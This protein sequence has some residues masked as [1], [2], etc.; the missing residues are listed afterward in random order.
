M[1]GT[2]VWV[3]CILALGLTCPAWGQDQNINEI[4][5]NSVL[6]EDLSYI[7]VAPKIVRPGHVYKAIVTLLDLDYSAIVIRG[8]VSRDGVQIASDSEK[9]TRQR[10]SI[11]LMMKVPSN[12]PA[13]DYKF[14]IDVELTD[15][16]T[17]L[18]TKETQLQFSSRS[19]TVVIQTNKAIYNFKDNVRARIV[20]LTTEQKPF[21]DP[22]D[23][24]VLEPLGY[25][26]RRWM[27]H[28]SS[29]GVMSISFKTSVDFGGGW[30]TIKVVAQ[31]QVIEQK[32]WIAAYFK[33]NIFVHV[34]APAFVLDSDEYIS[35]TVEVNKTKTLAPIYGSL[36]LHAQVKVPNRGSQSKIIRE[37]QKRIITQFYGVHNFRFPISELRS[38]IYPLPGA[39][40]EIRAKA[41][42]YFTNI[43]NT[44]YVRIRMINDT[45]SLRFL[46]T[47]PQ[48]F[49]PGMQF[50]TYIAVSYFD[51]VA[52]DPERLARSELTIVPDITGGSGSS[53]IGVIRT[54]FP[55]SGVYK[56][57]IRAPKKATKIEFRA[58]YRDDR[59]TESASLL[60]VA[61]YAPEEKY[62][63]VTTSTTNAMVGQFIVFH[64]RTN[65]HIHEFH[66]IVMSKGIIQM[67]ATDAV[68]GINSVSQSFAVPVSPAMS[69]STTLVVYAIT[70]DKKIIA[71]SVTV[72]V[73][74][75][76]RNQLYFGLLPKKDKTGKTIEM[77]ILNYPGAMTFIS[78]MDSASFD[79]QTKNEINQYN[80][81]NEMYKFEEQRNKL[82]RIVW[83]SRESM[84]STRHYYMTSNYGY[85]TLDVFKTV[86]LVIHSDMDVSNRTDPCAS[87]RNRGDR[88]GTST[89]TTLPPWMTGYEEDRQT[90]Y[91]SCATDYKC[92]SVLYRCDGRSHCFDK[93]DEANC[94]SDDDGMDLESA[95]FY[96]TR[97]NVQPLKYD[98]T[99]KD[100]AWQD[101]S[102]GPNE[103]TQVAINIPR[104]PTNWIFNAFSM[105]SE[106]GFGFIDQPVIHDGRIP[107]HMA[108]EAPPSAVVYEQIGVR[109]IA[110][111][112]L[113][114]E[115]EV[116]LNVKKSDK[117]QFVLVDGL[118][119]VSHYNPR[120][121]QNN[122]QH[123]IFIKPNSYK[124]VHFPVV[125][126]DEGKIVV[127]INGRA[128]VGV[129]QV[130]ATIKIVN[131]GAM[132]HHHTALLLNLRNI[133]S[134][135]SFLH[136]N[137][138]E[139]PIIPYELYRRY[140]WGSPVGRVSVS[141]DV[142]GPAFPKFPISPADLRLTNIRNGEAKAFE[143]G[144]H[145]YTL[146]Y[147]WIT[148]QWDPS[149]AKKVFSY[150][151]VAYTNL[152]A[153]FKNHYFFHLKA[154]RP[155][156]WLTAHVAR[157]L[158]YG[159]YAEWEN[160]LFID[161]RVISDS[162]GF[163][164]KQQKE[165]GSFYDKEDFP[166]DRKVSS[167]E[168][169]YP[170][171]D[172]F[173]YPT[174]KI[175]TVHQNIT[176][177]A[178]V[179]LTLIQVTELSG[180]LRIKSSSAKTRALNYLE[181][182]LPTITDPYTLSIVTYVLT[183]SNNVV[184]E[185]AFYMLDKMKRTQRGMIYWSREEVPPDEVFIQNQRPYI[186]PRK[187]R[188]FD[189]M[190]VETTAYA[191]LT[192]IRREGL[193]RDQIVEWLIKVK[194]TDAGF[195]STRDTLAAMEALIEYSYRSRVREVTDLQVKIEASSL[196]GVAKLFHINQDNLSKQQKIV[197]PDVHGNIE[198]ISTGG[199]L[200][201]LQL[202]VSFGV[203]RKR[204]M[205]PPPV[206]AF[207]LMVDA[208]Y[209]GR[210]NS[211]LHYD[212]C[213]RWNLLDQSER[214]G[215]AIMEIQLPTGYHLDHLIM[216][217][218]M[219]KF[220]KVSGGIVRDR[221][222]KFRFDS[223]GREFHCLNFTVHRWYPV[224]NLTR[225]MLARVY[226]Y[227]SPEFFTEEIIDAY[228]VHV[229][230]ICQACGSYQCPYCPDF[231]SAMVTA[232]ST[233]ILVAFSF[234]LSMCITRYKTFI[235]LIT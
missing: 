16:R 174:G 9:V 222:A 229:L 166:F 77:D 233:V 139:T 151:Q 96:M 154:N 185:K 4:F 200:A 48:I 163:I 160:F 132:Q 76:S 143:F 40:V 199:G 234:V 105:H 62:I 23:I 130:S 117:F 173:G 82:Q 172:P 219:S 89:T 124:I 176:L 67:A 1:I 155:S 221:M 191:L 65:V 232:S 20:M 79:S 87:M 164:V 73:N 194:Y 113:N 223:I 205:I 175:I 159:R 210:N 12:S 213:V 39:E 8:S 227:L 202:D 121:T 59:Y 28:Q 100:F 63:H 78:A 226:E 5:D 54:R 18:F 42:E 149:F 13:G 208:S 32:I 90:K 169:Q 93:S 220:P 116:L 153:H 99:G 147:Q 145:L 43:T 211:H 14:R 115:I 182:Q 70:D 192:Y 224:A 97:K 31:G 51:Q 57:K 212:V 81:L 102:I 120:T 44:G 138:T 184:G 140:V 198:A 204:V 161:P 225:F 133:P 170:E 109:V 10:M 3:T 6:R 88:F 91:L 22:V 49:K 53:D 165:D 129:D 64:L 114:Y 95:Q 104:R 36:V 201:L 203:D 157:I 123:L 74:G 69:P 217:A 177:T 162:I 144:Y 209:S 71:D 125:A 98:A 183:L 152:L 111:N 47:S 15:S 29:L 52:L 72:P 30:W 137:V 197:M 146:R 75:I 186:M 26:A 195:C 84:Q 33:P 179:A 94:E 101:I 142:V 11:T 214:S 80:V 235:D 25:I 193:V 83:R 136:I 230:S 187:K 34:D 141:G 60:A 150:L 178:Q 196:P 218:G 128:Q 158:Q 103:D 216:K 188:K 228:D 56:L 207:D 168:S 180:E 206:K 55:E 86:G 85:D 68:S 107:F 46:G 92:Y 38:L 61:A 50:V 112:Y 156:V 35:G 127:T 2:R 45:L 37:T 181:R 24:Y 41:M 131:E 118:G 119:D 134:Q 122:I 171:L 189:A 167:T 215:F 17:S 110:Y 135:L 190:N 27:S 19:L 148:D 231:S 66:Y 106:L 126:I 58:T 7:V 108:I 21:Q